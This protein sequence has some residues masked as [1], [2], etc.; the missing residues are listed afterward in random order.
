MVGLRAALDSLR[1]ACCQPSPR[2][3]ARATRKTRCSS[4]ARP[5]SAQLAGSSHQLALSPDVHTSFHARPAAGI[6]DNRGVMSRS[7][8]LS[9][10][11]LGLLS[12]VRAAGAQSPSPGA[13]A[14]ATS[15]VGVWTLN[16]ELER[17]A[18]HRGSSP[19]GRTMGGHAAD[20]GSSGGGMAVRAEAS[21]A[22]LVAA[23]LAAGAVAAVAAMPRTCSAGSRRCAR[24][25]KRRIG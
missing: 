12:P 5:L 3:P 4:R 15:I 25:W 24:S 17:S 7:L 10:S 1:R 6:R 2:A 18:H 20:R 13:R 22:D 16:K 14:Q 11:P 19:A 21:A 8:I 9:R 23:G